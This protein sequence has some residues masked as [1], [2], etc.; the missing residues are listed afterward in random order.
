[1]KSSQK[2]VRLSVPY[3]AQTSEFSCGPASLLMALKHLDPRLRLSRTLE[4]EVWRQCNMIGV[5]GADPYGLSI[6]LLQAGHDAHLV[7]G[8]RRA[9]EPAKWSRTLVAHGFEPEDAKLAIFGIGENRRRAL[10]RGLAVERAFPTV[11]VIEARVRAGWIPVALVH[12]G[13]VHELDV[14]HWVVVTGVSASEVAFNDPYRPR[15]RKGVRLPRATFQKI[16][17]DVRPMGMSPAVVFAR[18]R[19]AGKARAIPESD[20]AQAQGP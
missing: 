8:A 18:R 13:V 11:A 19:T 6:P 16:L 15:G 7:V 20:A 9:L 2:P 17:D 3:Y 10:A 14:P 1:V 5:R 4:Y 12:M